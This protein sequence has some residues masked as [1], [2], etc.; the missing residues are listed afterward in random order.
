MKSKRFTGDNND[1][2]QEENAIAENIPGE[3]HILIMS[4]KTYEKL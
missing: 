3:K 4:E 2:I 1:E